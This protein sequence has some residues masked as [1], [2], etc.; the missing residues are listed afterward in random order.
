MPCRVRHRSLAMR[1]GGELG[2]FVFVVWMW[3]P[4]ARETVYHA[5]LLHINPKDGV[6]TFYDPGTVCR[7][8]AAHRRSEHAILRQV[9]QPTCGQVM[10]PCPDMSARFGALATN[11]CI[12]PI[13][14][15]G[16]NFVATRADARCITPFA[17]TRH[18]PRGRC[19]QSLT[20]L[21]TN[22]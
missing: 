11:P 22:A 7:L 17:F 3:G 16:G 6:E 2:I 12:G 18:T 10:L 20:V 9:L 1:C 8:R 19:R 15:H 14:E 4:S 13:E 21:T 5:T